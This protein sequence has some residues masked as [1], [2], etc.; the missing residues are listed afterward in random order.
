MFIFLIFINKA[1]KKK[2][3]KNTSERKRCQQ[4]CLLKNNNK[5]IRE[6]NAFCRYIE[7]H[8]SQIMKNSYE[9]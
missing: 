3:C 8:V 2:K 9:I 6:K 7:A 5:S 1:K 4:S